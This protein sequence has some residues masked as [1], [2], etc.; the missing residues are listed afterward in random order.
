ME[1][2]MIDMVKKI[3]LTSLTLVLTALIAV[4]LTAGEVRGSEDIEESADLVLPY[5]DVLTGKMGD[6]TN[7]LIYVDGLGYRLCK[8]IKIFTPGNILIPLENIEGA[9]Q[10][11]IFKN[12]G[13]VRKIK[14][15]QFAQ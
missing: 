12:K 1:V 9:G 2:K 13:C 8:E 14:V 6:V 10:I 15:M 4:S 3:I 7:R 11:Q 5:D